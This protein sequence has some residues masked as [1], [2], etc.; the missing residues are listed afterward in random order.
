MRPSDETGE[1]TMFGTIKG[2]IP[3]PRQAEQPRHYTGRH[4]YVEPPANP[5]LT[6]EPPATASGADAPT[7][8]LAGAAASAVGRAPAAISPVPASPDTDAGQ[9][10]RP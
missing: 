5:H 1:V 9:Q 4:R 8:E 3:E 6:A 7:R 10:T 2:L